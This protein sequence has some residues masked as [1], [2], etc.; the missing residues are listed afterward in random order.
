MGFLLKLGRYCDLKVYGPKEQEI[1]GKEISPFDY[2][3][4]ITGKDLIEEI[5]PDIF[6]FV[7]WIHHC[8]D[9]LPKDISKTGIPFVVLEEDHHTYKDAEILSGT[10]GIDRDVLDWYKELDVSLLL[11]R[12]FYHEAAPVS[13]VWFPFSVNEEEFYPDEKMVRKDKIGYV[14]ASLTGNVIIHRK[15]RQMALKALGEAGL[16]ADNIGTIG[17]KR[18]PEYLRSYM[19]AL[20]CSGGYIHTCLAKTFEIP[21]SGTALLTN[22][23]HNEKE[24]FGDK[25]CYFAY[26][27]DCSDIVNTAKIILEDK[28]QRNEVIANALKVVKER[29]TD[30]ARLLELYN[31][32]RALLSE[33]E[34]PRI[35]GQ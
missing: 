26:K 18:F 13:S 17:I 30:S 9:W 4:D 19:G 29:H 31:I 22:W 6:L 24:L 25:K 3:Q 20:T 8:R 34:I 27:D 12:H 11:R 1:N 21:L 5:K 7:L 14:G 10:P 33:V 23:V 28:E 32:L 35:W 2:R 16:L 15:V